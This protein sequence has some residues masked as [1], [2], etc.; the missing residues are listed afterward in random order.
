MDS[1]TVV[2][3]V[4]VFEGLIFAVFIGWHLWRQQKERIILEMF[5]GI[6]RAVMPREEFEAECKRGLGDGKIMPEHAEVLFQRMDQQWR[7]EL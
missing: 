3:A 6:E 5:D 4:L 2:V 1:M 7:D